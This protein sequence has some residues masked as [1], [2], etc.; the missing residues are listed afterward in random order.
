MFLKNRDISSKIKRSKVTDY[1]T[2][3]IYKHHQLIIYLSSSYYMMYSYR[4]L[5]EIK[6]NG[7]D[8]SASHVMVGTL[9]ISTRL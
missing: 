8:C 3:S 7:R 2:L 6:R 1:A 4:T 9:K 5:Q